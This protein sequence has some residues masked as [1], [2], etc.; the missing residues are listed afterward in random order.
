M[1][2]DW[3]VDE[4]TERAMELYQQAAELDHGLAH[5]NLANVYRDPSYDKQDLKA[6]LNHLRQ[7]R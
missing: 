3:F 6:A 7:V 5:F 4:D 2:G 1:N